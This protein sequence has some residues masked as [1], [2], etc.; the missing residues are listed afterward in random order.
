[1]QTE[2]V[3]VRVPKNEAEILKKLGDSF[4]MSATGLA[5]I[6]LRAAIGAVNREQ[7]LPL[8]I[9]FDLKEDAPFSALNDLAPRYAPKPK[10]KAK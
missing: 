7:R 5:A 1:M 10:P 8:P 6:L 4:S 2:S 9:K 3:H